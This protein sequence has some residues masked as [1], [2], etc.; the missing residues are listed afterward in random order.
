[1]TPQIP[2]A[3]PIQRPR[4]LRAHIVLACAIAPLALACFG[5]SANRVPVSEA[6]MEE[7]EQRRLGLTLVGTWEHAETRSAPDVDGVAGD[8]DMM[9]RFD[10][11][12]TFYFQSGSGR[13]PVMGR[14]W[15]EGRNLVLS[16]YH[17]DRPTTYRVDEWSPGQML[18][19]SYRDA[20]YYLVDRADMIDI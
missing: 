20:T 16:L 1:M 7:P 10:K 9:W 5:S 2:S 12:G 6:P 3:R 13:P 17:T 19:F 14:W 18:L 11:S 8:P 15:L 4:S